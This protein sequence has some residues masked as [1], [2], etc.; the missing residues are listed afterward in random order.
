MKSTT[1]RTIRN[2]FA[3]LISNDAAI[4][5]AKTAPWWIAILF[6]VIGTF[7]PIIP[8]MVNTS[9]TYG[10]S[11]V[12][13]NTYGY[14]EALAHT[15]VN[16]KIAGYEFNVQDGQLI[17]TI[18]GEVQQKCWVDDKDLQPIYSYNGI[19]ND[20]NAYRALNVYYTDRPF[21]SS[22]KS[23]KSM[24]KNTLE[25]NTYYK[26]TTLAVSEATEEQK[27]AYAGQKNVTYT[28]SY[29]VLYKDG[30]YSK[31]FKYYTSTAAATTYEGMDWKRLKLETGLLEYVTKV[32]TETAGTYFDTTDATIATKNRFIDGALNNWKV[33]FN[34]GYLNQK[35][36]TF[37]FNS[38]LYYGIYLLLGFFMG[39]LM[40]L[41]TRGKNNPNRNLTLWIGFKISM[42]ITVSPAVLAMAVGFFFS[43]AAGIGYIALIGIRTMWLSMRQLNP[44]V[45]QQ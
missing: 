2:V 23:V 28:P 21:S 15:S 41:L 7:L 13:S 17:E 40:W 4:E 36:K 43:P 18:N 42:W 9:K 31:I 35:T 44:T 1:K 8:I 27:A 11:F 19:D 32:E 33:V 26:G 22:D 39:L 34:K 30:L 3:S 38:G 45:S 12:A 16:L 6:L 10:A 14:E 25:K 20:G 37:W 5:G 29:L 24:I